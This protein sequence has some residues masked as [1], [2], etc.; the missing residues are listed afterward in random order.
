MR[1]RLLALARKELIRPDRAEFAGEDAFRFRHLLIRDAAYQAMPKEQRAEL[2]EGFARWLTDVSGDQVGEYQEILGHHLEQAYRYRSELGPADDRM[3]VL[4]RDAAR[5]LHTSAE[6]AMVR[7]DLPGAA[8]LL[9]RAI[10]LAEGLARARAIVDLG[11]ILE[12]RGEYARDDP[13]AR[14]VPGIAG[15]SRCARPADPSGRVHAGLRFPDG[16]RTRDRRRA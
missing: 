3:R 10:D 8:H 7:G 4:A 1:P 2:H 14:R 16:A 9:E 12:A 6:R 5:A 11:E 15:G 13:G